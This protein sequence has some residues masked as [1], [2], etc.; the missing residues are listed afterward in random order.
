MT[1]ATPEEHRTLSLSEFAERALEG[2]AMEQELTDGRRV[3]LRVFAPTQADLMAAQKLMMRIVKVADAA[4]K[5]ADIG[6]DDAVLAYELGL[7][8]LRACVRDENGAQIGDAALSDLFGK[9]PYKA[10]VMI[11]CQELCG[12]GL[13]S[14]PPLDIKAAAEAI[15]AEAKAAA[16]AAKPNRKSRRAAKK[17]G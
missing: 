5:E 2:E 14:V 9:L 12:V 8:C 10:P 4:G 17:K 6:E 7:A 3:A 13:M 1:D 11:R 15:G 16:E